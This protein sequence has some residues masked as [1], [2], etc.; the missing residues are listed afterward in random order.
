ML[1]GYPCIQ[2][3]KNWLCCRNRQP[4][5]TL[6]RGINSFVTP[7]GD[8]RDRTVDLRLA[9]PALSQLSYIP[10]AFRTRGARAPNEDCLVGPSR[11][12]LPT[13]RLSGVRSN[14]LSYGPTSRPPE[15][16]RPLNLEYGA[17][18]KH[19]AIDL[20]DE[21][22]RLLILLRK[23]VIQPHLPIRLPCYDFIPLTKHT[24]GTSLPCGLGQ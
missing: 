4:A 17:R 6:T 19:C 18:R 5:Y 7:G 11:I 20:G 10:G 9:K 8:E 13:S 22:R 1:L 24:F 23:E 15:P 2:L 16:E 12:E 3:S 14:Q 21:N